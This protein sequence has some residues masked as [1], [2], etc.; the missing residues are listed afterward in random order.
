MLKPRVQVRTEGGVLIA[1]FW[2]CLRLDPAPVSDLRKEFDAH[3]RSQGRPDLLVD[4]HGVAFAGSAALGGFL[5]LN[6]MARQSGGRIVFCRVDPNVFEVFRASKL[7]PLFVFA[8]DIPAAL[9]VMN[10]PANTGEAAPAPAA[11]PND[12]QAAEGQAGA[13]GERVRRKSS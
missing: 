8:A 7:M 12:G 13:L 5:A 6:R 4:L 10:S 1:E 3:R 2:D 11:P 9:A